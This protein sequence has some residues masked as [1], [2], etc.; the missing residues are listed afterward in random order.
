MKLITLKIASAA[1]LIAISTTFSATVRAQTFSKPVIV[2]SG[3]VRADETAQ[4]TS[5][6]V[7]IREAGDTA[8][9]ITCSTSNKQT[10]R[11]LVV[12]SPN[13]KYWVHLE[14]DS[15]LTKDLLISTPPAAQTQQFQQDFTVALRDTDDATATKASAQ[16]N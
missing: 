6:K 8:M 13:K 1:A 2:M 15:I 11:Y 10:G 12:L 3:I 4:P 5:V 7:S 14:G 9:E 16:Q